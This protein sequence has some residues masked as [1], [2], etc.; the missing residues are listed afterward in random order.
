MTFLLVRLSWADIVVL[1]DGRKYEGKITQ[2]TDVFVTLNINGEDT[3]LFFD[4]VAAINDEP[5]NFFDNQII[6]KK[7][8]ISINLDEYSFFRS[9][10][11][12]WFYIFGWHKK[13]EAQ[14]Q[15]DEFFK[16]NSSIQKEGQTVILT[17][18]V[19]AAMIR[20]AENDIPDLS[21]FKFDPAHTSKET[22]PNIQFFVLEKNKDLAN[23]YER[24]QRQFRLVKNEIRKGK[25]VQEIE[26]VE[27]KGLKGY[28]FIFKFRQDR[29]SLIARV[30][31][32]YVDGKE[33]VLKAFYPR[34]YAEEVDEI[35]GH[36]KE[37]LIIYLTQ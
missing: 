22:N 7:G 30:F 28:Q 19:K 1:N 35:F 16:N 31:V 13:D 25:I 27:E 3:V 15:L 2:Q 21:C 29:V 14:K 32:T 17:D 8:T 4:Q 6:E 20:D 9:A 18:D 34:I 24:V 11:P 36:L 33:Y 26:E 12:E 37:D 5:I 23:D 10:K